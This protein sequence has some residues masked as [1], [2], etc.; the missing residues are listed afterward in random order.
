MLDGM[1]DAMD[2]EL[3]SVVECLM[4]FLDDPIFAQKRKTLGRPPDEALG[5]D[6]KGRIF[7]I[8]PIISGLALFHFRARLHKIGL[9]MINETGA[10]TICAHPSN[11]AFEEGYFIP[12][13]DIQFAIKY[14]GENSFFV[15]G[16][17][18]KRQDY[19][20]RF[21]MQCG[22]PAVTFAGHGRRG[23]K[24]KRMMYDFVRHRNQ[25]RIIKAN[26]PISSIFVDRYVNN[27][28]RI[29]LEP[30]DIGRIMSE[31][32]SSFKGP[33]RDYKKVAKPEK[34]K[35]G[36]SSE[37][38]EE[39]QAKPTA[40]LMSLVFWLHAEAMD[41]AFPYFALESTCWVVLRGVNEICAPHM[42]DIFDKSPREN[43]KQTWA[44]MAELVGDILLAAQWNEPMGETLFRL[45][46]RALAIRLIETT[47]TPLFREMM[48][49]VPL[50]RRENVQRLAQ[51]G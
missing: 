4:R 33:W 51:G 7:K 41:M 25:R 49:V 40:L 16:L 20:K 37:S 8:S 47:P 17:P 30:N 3:R 44:G 31:A 11:A 23:A 14:L 10:T 1:P 5:A 48:D 2:S 38:S 34:G 18:T 27:S 26:T 43:Y 39:E 46:G 21:L 50:F 24:E 35:A 19:L 22:F 29:N 45:S 12:H 36:S 13:P 6:E 32:R 15:G 9:E 42:M 28:S